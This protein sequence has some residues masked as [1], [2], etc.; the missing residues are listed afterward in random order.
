MKSQLL[1]VSGQNTR[2]SGG[3]Q[4]DEVRTHADF[5]RRSGAPESKK[6]IHRLSDLGDDILRIIFEFDTTYR[7]IFT[8]KVENGIWGAAWRN[9]YAYSEDC[10]CPFV[11]TVMDSLFQSWGVN[12]WGNPVYNPLYDIMPP[13]VV[14]KYNY[15]PSDIRIVNHTINDGISHYVSVYI[16]N[17]RILYCVVATIEYYNNSYKTI[18]DDRESEFAELMEIFVDTNKGY[19][20][21]LQI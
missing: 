18:M 12:K 3:M 13:I 20:I 14:Y 16:N 6:K 17:Q 2:T 11:E 7:E 8:N 21:L 5:W 10:Q 15:F 1:D 4:E 9:W 19:V